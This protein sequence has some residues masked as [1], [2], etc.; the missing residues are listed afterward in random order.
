MLTLTVNL[1]NVLYQ[2]TQRANTN[3][4]VAVV[5]SVIYADLNAAGY[6]RSGVSFRSDTTLNAYS[7]Q[8][9]YFYSDIVSGGGVE[10]IKYYTTYS[11]ASKLY[12]LYRQV[13]NGTAMVLA[14]NLSSFAFSYYDASGVVTAVKSSIKQVRV[15]MTAEYVLTNAFVKTKGLSS[16]TTYVSTDIRVIPPN[17]IL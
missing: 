5:D 9:L 7:A 8:S 14:N 3:S 11:S 2:S 4:L 10:L 15:M 13:N 17:L 6:A 16:D 12:T 1:N